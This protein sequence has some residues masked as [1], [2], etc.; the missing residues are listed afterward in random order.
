V[1]DRRD[2]A[3]HLILRGGDEQRWTRHVGGAQSRVPADR[4][5]R[6]NMESYL[7]NQADGPNENIGAL[8][9]ALLAKFK[10]NGEQNP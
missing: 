5:D 3:R 9:E 6:K 8:G 4:L 7:G 10:A 1:G 2:R